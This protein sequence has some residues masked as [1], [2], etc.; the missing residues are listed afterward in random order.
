M[1]RIILLSTVLF[2]TLTGCASRS[3]YT[4]PDLTLNYE[5]SVV[6]VTNAPVEGA[7]VKY[8]LKNIDATFMEATVVTGS[9]G[10][11]VIS[12]VAPP[13]RSLRVEFDYRVAKEG[14][15]S[16]S[17]AVISTA[18]E[19]KNHAVISTGG[20]YTGYTLNKSLLASLFRP[21][22]YIKPSFLA[23]TESHSIN[24]SILSL[25][26]SFLLQ[27]RQTNTIL[28]TQ[29]IYLSSFKERAYLRFVLNSTTSYNSLRLNKYEVA[30]ELFD[31]VIRKALNPLTDYLA[32]SN[33]FYGYDISI[34]GYTRNFTDEYAVNQPILYR[35][36]IPK[37]SVNKYKQK[38]ISGQQLLDSSVILMNDERIDLKLQ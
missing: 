16:H 28:E 12:T 11:V 24:S 22:D 31:E 19:Y 9:T 2:L 30:K 32:N 35:F 23:S 10:K 7:T 17:D 3:S 1:K 25:I 26:E 5:I 34:T 36:L 18:S 37:E 21:S 20:E 14:Y 4:N 13:A 38:D 29:S 33:A 15:I 8:T 6:D 27:C